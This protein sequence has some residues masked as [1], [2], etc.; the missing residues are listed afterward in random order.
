M[1]CVS[2]ASKEVRGMVET[3]AIFAIGGVIVAV[4]V[5]VAYLVIWL[6]G[7]DGTH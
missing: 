3:I 1:A 6:F 5:A 7:N 2:S 4:S